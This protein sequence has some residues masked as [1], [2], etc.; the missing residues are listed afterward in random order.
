MSIAES[1]SQSGF[2]RFISSSAGRF[3]RG[4]AG[5]GLIAWGYPDR[6]SSTG[7]VLMAVGVLFVVVGVFNL[8]LISALLGGP[9]SGSRMGA[10][11]PQP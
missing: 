4:V 11:T 10:R 2:A 8:C 5:A 1:F 6:S 9:I 3:I 7:L